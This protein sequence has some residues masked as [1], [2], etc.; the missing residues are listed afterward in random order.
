MNS[1]FLVNFFLFCLV[2]SSFVLV[3]GMEEK[4]LPKNPANA[5]LL[6]KKIKEYLKESKTGKYGSMHT[7]STCFDSPPTLKA[8]QLYKNLCG[9]CNGE[10]EDGRP[11]L[12]N[13]VDRGHPEEVEM[14]LLAGADP[15]VQY[16]G[17][18][19]LS[20]ACACHN[21]NTKIIKKLLSFGA[22]VDYIYPLGGGTL[23]H[24]VVGKNDEVVPM[25]L[26]AQVNPEIKDYYG[27]TFFELLEIQ[28]M[29]ENSMRADLVERLKRKAI[30]KQKVQA[31][32]DAGKPKFRS[33]YDSIQFPRDT[34]DSIYCHLM[35][36]CN[37]TDRE[38]QLPLSVAAF[39]GNEQ[40]AELLLLA[41]AD[42]N[43]GI[44]PNVNYNSPLYMAV[45]MRNIESAQLLIEYGASVNQKD[46]HD[47]TPLSRAVFNGDVQIISVLLRAGAKVNYRDPSSGGTLLHVACNNKHLAVAKILHD[48]GVD[49]AIRDKKG[50]TALEQIHKNMPFYGPCFPGVNTDLMDA[51]RDWTL[52]DRERQFEARCEKQRL[53]ELKRKIKDYLDL[54]CPDFIHL[55]Q[56][57]YHPKKTADF[58]YKHLLVYCNT[59]IKNSLDKKSLPIYEAIRMCNTYV[60]EMLLLAGADVKGRTATGEYRCL[61]SP[62]YEAV[63]CGNPEMI[64]LL[65]KSEVD[66]NR[67]GDDGWTPLHR[68]AFLSTQDW[69]T[70][71]EIA[72]LLLE[73]G[74]DRSLKDKEDRTPYQLACFIYG[75]F[76]FRDLVKIV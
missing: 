19:P 71:I 49:A 27:R 58:I 61:N 52:K 29:E 10:A 75:D 42:P 16:R 65:L 36:Y 34:V 73:Y 74:A 33:L 6:K 56:F 30:L 57:L 23:L 31:Y 54:G 20:A 35:K 63:A 39:C 21:P 53:L 76:D 60:L 48:V 18:T 37:T 59:Q 51:V 55:Q 7:F 28:P 9:Y 5:P 13:A 68:A 47:Q 22:K 26:D 17:M 15:N 14:V 43:C 2:I 12:I 8:D 11:V 40:I 41:G 25:L 64:R 67:K 3:H 66:P 1:K 72:K 38:N 45:Y 46:R 62:L 44:K 4:I 32:V 24:E 50:R 69:S 70:S